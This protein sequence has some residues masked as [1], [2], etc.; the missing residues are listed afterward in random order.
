[1]VVAKPGQHLVA[2]AFRLEAGELF[3]LQQDGLQ[4]SSPAG[5]PGRNAF[6]SWE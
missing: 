5:L 1:V 3:V 2:I 4:Y 6:L